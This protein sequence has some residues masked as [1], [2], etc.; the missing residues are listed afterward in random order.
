MKKLQAFIWGL[1]S[2]AILVWIYWQ[3]KMVDIQME[4]AYLQE[5]LKAARTRSENLERQLAARDAAAPVPAKVDNPS[6][7][8]TPVTASVRR[9]DL[10]VING[11]G[12]VIAGKLNQAGIY[13]YEALANLTPD[14]LREIVG[15]AI[16]RL[17]N[18][19][20]IIVQARRL[21]E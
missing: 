1:I 17:A 7:E 3:Q 2:G 14:Q 11:I 5:Q 21:S 15:N 9:D 12:P 8:Q 4:E 20:E 13:S 10:T 16:S 6:S 19:E 18:E